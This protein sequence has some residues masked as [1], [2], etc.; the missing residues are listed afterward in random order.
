M[1]REAGDPRLSTRGLPPPG[2]LGAPEGGGRSGL[3]PDPRLSEH[4]SVTALAPPLRV[5]VVNPSP[6]QLGAAA[7]DAFAG[8]MRVSPR[9]S[10][11][12]YATKSLILSPPASTTAASALDAASLTGAT[13]Q[14]QG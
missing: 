14:L 8:P 11:N 2:R 4:E 13:G 6:K 5:D 1:L 3:E 10:A 12:P 9:L 7:I